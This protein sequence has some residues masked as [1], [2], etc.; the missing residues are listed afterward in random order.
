MNW[1]PRQ[2]VETALRGE[3][4]PVVPFTM[5]EQLAPQCETERHLRNRGMCLVRRLS[6]Y[7]QISP[8]VK[9]HAI[10]TYENGKQLVRTI[11]ETPVGTVESRHQPAGFTSWHHERLFKSPDDYK[12]L[13]FMIADARFEPN[14][15]AMVAAD[16][17]GGADVIVRASIGAEPLQELVSGRY[18]KT[19]TFCI[20]WM[21][22]RDEVLKLYDLLVEQ[23]RKVYDIV[24][25]CPALIANYGGNVSPEIIS[26][27]NFAEYYIP[28][29]N[30]A[31][32]ALHRHG[33][34]IGVHF[35]AN[36]KLFAKAIAD[37]GLDY[38]EAFT[39]APD[40]DMSLADARAA[41]PDKVLWL[42]YPSSLHLKSDEEVTR[43]T[44]ELLDEAGTPDGVI[45]GIT[46][47]MPPNRWRDSCSAI[48]SGL[49]RHAELNPQMYA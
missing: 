41:W 38:V 2:R 39:P 46:E 44:V 19:E 1:T 16:R 7:R 20:E 17:E 9:A 26:P 42:N 21:E 18:M 49:E 28:N 22:N 14:Y 35:D 4:G 31:A 40:T 12:T 32:E 24:A 36:C 48:V 43:A 23:R 8:N 3:H 34:M 45:M 25:Q 47:N 13:R 33:K 27:A 11:F 6:P 30:E 10:T 37:S 15:A 5:Y 29:Y